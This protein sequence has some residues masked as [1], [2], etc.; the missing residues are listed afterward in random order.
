MDLDNVV[1]KRLRGMAVRILGCIENTICCH[2]DEMDDSEEF[3]LN[4]SDLKI[5]RSEILNAAG[6]TTRALAG[7]TDTSAKGGKL[8]LPREVLGALKSAEVTFVKDGED[9]V[10][11]F[12][13]KGEFWLIG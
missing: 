3:K 1:Q 7:L 4:G 6:D 5:I 2:L 10:P 12:R 8:S 9:D 11:V 13:V